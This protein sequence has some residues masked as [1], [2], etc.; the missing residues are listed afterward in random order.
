MGSSLVPLPRGPFAWPRIARAIGF[1]CASL[2]LA[3]LVVGV[4]ESGAGIPDASEVYL[5]AVVS[6]AI[7]FGTV[8]A[9]ATAVGGTLLYDVLFTQPLY[10]FV[11][12]D[13]REWLN[14]VLFLLI[15]VVV[16]RLAA[17]QQERAADADRRAREAQALFAISRTL[18]TE[19]S[20][21][22]AAPAVLARLATDS[23][24]RR[25]W[26]SVGTATSE[27]TI[28]DTDPDASRP[29]LRSQWTMV[30]APGD[31]PATWLR[32]HTGGEPGRVGPAHDALFR[33][34]IEVEGNTVGSLWGT[35]PANLGL[36]DRES[37]RL[38]ALAA[39]QLGLGLRRDELSAAA[40]AAEI[41]RQGDALKTALLTSVS[42]DLR[43]PLASI[44]AA[45]GSLMDPAV[46]WNTAGVRE[47]ARAIDGEA[48]RLNRLVRNLLDLSRIEGGALRPDLEVFQLDDLLEPVIAR[49]SQLFDGHP[50][51]LEIPVELPAVRADAVY[52]DEAVTNLLEN[53][54]RYA[55]KGARVCVSAEQRGP[56]TIRLTVE[57]D[58]PGVPPEALPRLFEKFYR[59][60][61]NASGSRRGM[62]IGMSVVKG[63]VEAMGGSV[64][65]RPSRLGG[66]AVDI[67]LPA[68]PV[69]Q[70]GR[71]AADDAGTEDGPG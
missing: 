4:L 68:V 52:L 51:I 34:K 53:A 43:T 19:T 48:D 11:V 37:T 44:R 31:R 10:A 35:R 18:A 49:V 38:L 67:D 28:V 57:D 25:I 9:M 13:P 45:A 47:T 24:M 42:H 3:S 41:A 23:G 21:A 39:D 8:P 30:R 64:G 1:A 65:A 70:A 40:N 36:P 56:G 2:A 58:G 5:V 12:S 20:V 26:L 6:V 69:P 62:G 66:L 17:L 50:V 32:T 59:V 71:P 27:R 14:L 15:A 29:A 46:D 61:A 63:L 54:A 55:G 7:V 60:S 33:V 22:Q 16:G